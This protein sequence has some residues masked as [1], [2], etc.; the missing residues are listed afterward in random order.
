MAWRLS[1]Y[2]P[3]LVII[4]QQEKFWILS[5]PKIEI[6]SLAEW[7]KALGIVREQLR[8]DFGDIG[9]SLKWLD[10]V[11]YD[12]IVLAELARRLLQ[13]CNFT[14]EIVFNKNNIKVQRELN[15]WAETVA[16]RN[17]NDPAKQ[18]G[19]TIQP[20]IAL[21]LNSQFLATKNLAEFFDSYLERNTDALIDLQVK[22]IETG[23]NATIVSLAGTAGDR[24]EELIAKATSEFTQKQLQNAPDA[25]PIV[26][27]RFGQDSKIFDYPLG[28]LTPLVTAETVDKFGLKYGELLAQTKIDYQERCRLLQSAKQRVDCALSE[29]HISLDKALNSKSHEYLFWKPKVKLSDTQLLFGNNVSSKKSTTLM[30][31][32]QGGVYRRHPDFSDRN[33]PIRLGI[34]NLSKLDNK[35]IED[36]KTQLQAQLNRYGFKSIIPEENQKKISLE[37]LAGAAIRITLEETIINREVIV[38]DVTETPRERP[39]KSGCNRAEVSSA[40]VAPSNKKCLTVAKRKSIH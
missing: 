23:S 2:F 37:N 12:A 16:L 20:A 6:S 8:E 3:S 28:A 36:F 7:G 22:T 15:F 18:T 32:N 26:S 25:Q 31:L 24:R 21:T 11:K 17:S 34:L 14:L 13:D 35:A 38:V 19:R 33:K 39:Q 10:R 1:K 30:G 9:Y 40:C 27:I 29:Y 4:W 5:K